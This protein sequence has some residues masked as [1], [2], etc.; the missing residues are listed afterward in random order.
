[1]FE[2]SFSMFLNSFGAARRNLNVIP[3]RFAYRSSPFYFSK[4]PEALAMM[5]LWISRCLNWVSQHLILFSALAGHFVVRLDFQTK[6]QHISRKKAESNFRH[7]RTL[8]SANRKYFSY[9]CSICFRPFDSRIFLLHHNSRM[10]V[11]TS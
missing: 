2:N 9:R 5:F 1:M 11:L 4:H 6:C 7:F 3:D 10:F 8:R